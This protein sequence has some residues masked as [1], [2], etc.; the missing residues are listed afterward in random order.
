[1]VLLRKRAEFND[2]N[3]LRNIAMCYASGK[4]GLPVDQAKCVDLLR[5]SADHGCLEAQY[6]LGVY[7]YDG[8]MGVEQNGYEA[9][10]WWERAAEGGDLIALHNLG[11]LE[12]NNG[13]HVAAMR[14]YRLSASVGNKDSME[15]LIDY[16]EYGLLRHGDL[17]KTVQAFYLARD[18]IM[19][20]DRNQYIAHL[21]RTG[22]YREGYDM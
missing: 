16:F 12:Q 11:G 4:L 22:K 9:L 3:A 21:K 20:E 5:Q 2:P 1:M 15:A 7:H 17:A 10:K 6:Q 13:N 8:E 18:E 14:H 19:S